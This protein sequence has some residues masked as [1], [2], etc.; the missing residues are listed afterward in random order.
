MRRYRAIA[1]ARGM[2]SAY[3][4]G[5]MQGFARSV[6]DPK[7][8]VDEDVFEEFAMVRGIEGRMHRARDLH[9]IRRALFLDYGKNI[10]P[11]WLAAAA[12][13]IEVVA[14]ADSALAGHVRK[15]RGIPVVNDSIAHRLDYDAAIVSNSSPVHAHKRASTWQR[16]LD[17]R[18]TINLL[19]PS[20]ECAPGISTATDVSAAAPAAFESRQTVARSA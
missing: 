20:T 7:R 5:F 3:W 13:R 16:T 17:G 18:V 2:N 8:T 10:L 4:L 11:Y 19:D 12:C 14:I 9:G 1:A 6:F 15:Y